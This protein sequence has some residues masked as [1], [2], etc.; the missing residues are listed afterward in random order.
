MTKKIFLFF[1]CVYMGILAA[2]SS[3]DD[4]L[5]GK[6]HKVLEVSPNLEPDLDADNVNIELASPITNTTWTHSSSNTAHL[7]PHTEFDHE[8]NIIWK[9]S[10]GHGTSKDSYLITSPIIDE[11]FVFTLDAEGEVRARQADS[12]KKIW[13]KNLPLKGTITHCLGG[14][15]ATYQGKLYVSFSSGDI[16]CLDALNGAVLWH[17]FSGQPIRSAPTIKYN[18][19]YIVTKQNN[20]I[21]LNAL[22]G[23]KVW[24]HEGASEVCSFLGGGAVAVNKHIIIAPYATGEIFALKAENGL[25]L[26]SESLSASHTLSS[27]SMVAQIKIDPVI[28][29]NIV[30]V[31]SQGGRMAALNFK[32]GNRIWE[33]DISCTTTPI[34]SDSF[35]FTL[36]AKGEVLCL[37]KETGKVI[38]IKSLATQEGL[39][40]TDWISTLLAGHKLYVTN[41]SGKIFVLDIKTGD[42]L[43]TFSVP[44]PLYLPPV[45][46]NKVLYFLN[47]H[48]TLIAV[49]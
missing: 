1:L 31:S 10:A 18:H 39:R 17:S 11:G 19:I 40:N 41:S 27:T 9:E 6:R 48:G 43:H 22:T 20:V 47:D 5:A 33:K 26:W 3:K 45:I 7:I 37:I 28:D 25:P 38:W 16:F 35:M 4:L 49:K 15:I 30:F 8:Y 24:H 23:E 34:I 29:K 46:A 14:G 42:I 44:G 2:C 13:T 32:T 36:T 21:A 12:G